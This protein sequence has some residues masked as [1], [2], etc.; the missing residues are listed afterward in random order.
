MCEGPTLTY[1]CVTPLPVPPPCWAPA[2]RL[3]LG[4]VRGW[5]G[6]ILAKA[7]ELVPSH[8]SSPGSWMRGWVSAGDSRG[9]QPRYP[10]AVGF[11]AVLWSVA[12]PLFLKNSR[13][14][15]RVAEDSSSLCEFR[16]G[17]GQ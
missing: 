7:P 17:H 14:I 13:V 3:P 6:Y 10:S 12:S 2:G 1:G 4:S 8:D 9:W 16:A 15:Y 5:G 11:R